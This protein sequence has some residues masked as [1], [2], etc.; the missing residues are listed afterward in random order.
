MHANRTTI[1]ETCLKNLPLPLWSAFKQFSLLRN[2]RTEP[3]EQDF[4]DWLLHLGN[5]T[6]TKNCQLGDVEIPEECV[7]T[8]SIVD[9]IFGS[10]VIDFKNLSEK[11]T[12]SQE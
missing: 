11:A 5:G 10:A 2:M 7:V 3:D 8:E 12:V 1:I 6:W 9:E 4:A